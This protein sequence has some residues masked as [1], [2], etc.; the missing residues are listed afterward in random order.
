[1]R[2]AQKQTIAASEND[3]R[4]NRLG[5][6]SAGQIDMLQNHIDLFQAQSTQI[7]K[8]C[9]GLA[10]LVT[11]G[12]VLLTF[13]RVLLLPIALAIELVI[14]G[15]MVYLTSSVS[16]FAQQLVYDRESEA[17]RIIKG[18]ASRYAMRTHPFYHSLRV[19]LE[20]YKLLDPSLVRQFATGEL[21]QLYV[22]PHSGVIIAAELIGEKGFRYLH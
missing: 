7:I 18:R 20:T 9:V 11:I 5:L 22:L 8:R 10:I 14:V 4:N 17:V 15:I 1:M 21:Y 6:M 13:V 12:V 16:R 2:A 3:L 19:E